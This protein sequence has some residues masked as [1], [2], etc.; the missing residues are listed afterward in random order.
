MRD[1]VALHPGRL[2][3][4]R[5]FETPAARAKRLQ[6]L[7]EFL[8]E[9]ATNIEQDNYVDDPH[10]LLVA[11]LDHEGPHIT[12]QG[13]TSWDEL[14]EIII[15]LNEQ[16]GR[17]FGGPEQKQRAV[18]RMRQRKEQDRLAEAA[19]IHDHPWLCEFCT[20]RFTTERGAK[21]HERACYQRKARQSHG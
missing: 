17:R 8:R 14:H 16:Y 6:A 2:P 11:F 9:L 4:F 3:N 18:Q 15:D 12:W 10:A 20:R 7:S 5:D 1:V 19:Y 13:I 21:V